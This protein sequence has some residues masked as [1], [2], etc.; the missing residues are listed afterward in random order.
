MTKSAEVTRLRKLPRSLRKANLVYK[1]VMA[2]LTGMNI[3]LLALNNSSEITIP[4]VYFEVISV[5]ATSF[6]LVWSK[7]LDS[8]K[9]YEDEL[10]PNTSLETTMEPEERHTPE[11]TQ[12]N[13]V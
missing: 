8:C 2:L 5:L 10:T 7:I 11:S 4:S 12:S 3:T 9:D 13:P 6:P 1:F